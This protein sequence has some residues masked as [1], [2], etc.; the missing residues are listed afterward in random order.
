MRV[1][2][3]ME[4]QS[5]TSVQE[6][7]APHTCAPGCPREEAAFRGGQR[8]CELLWMFCG[9]SQAVEFSVSDSFYPF[10]PRVQEN[11]RKINVY[12]RR[13]GEETIGREQG[14]TYFFALILF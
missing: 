3:G 14:P 9:W 1:R 6:H 4:V 7:K 10:H 8:G 11:H 5:E 2:M 12:Y 13:T